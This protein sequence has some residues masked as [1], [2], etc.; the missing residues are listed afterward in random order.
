MTNLLYYNK[1]NCQLAEVKVLPV[2]KIILAD[3]IY[4]QDEEMKHFQGI[5]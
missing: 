5:P 3:G 2:S 1:L 4:F